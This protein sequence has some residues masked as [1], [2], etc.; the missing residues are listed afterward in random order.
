MAAAKKGG[1]GRGLDALFA[2]AV[3]VYDEAGAV[4][5]QAKY[6]EKKGTLFLF[7]VQ[8]ECGYR[9]CGGDCREEKKNQN[10]RGLKMFAEIFGYFLFAGVEQHVKKPAAEGNPETGQ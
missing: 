8:P 10:G 6:T 2:D 5:A 9:N 3:P 7:P 4:K 1:L